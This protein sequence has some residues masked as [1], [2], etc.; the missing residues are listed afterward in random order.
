MSPSIGP[1]P[2]IPEWP[3][4]SHEW[5]LCDKIRHVCTQIIRGQAARKRWQ[6]RTHITLRILSIALTALGGAGLIVQKQDQTLLQNTGWAFWGGL[7]VLGVGILVQIADLFGIERIATHAKLISLICDR[8]E[9][10]LGI[11]LTDRDPRKRLN[12][13]TNRITVLI[14]EPNN[15]E[16]LPINSRKFT[17]LGRVVGDQMIL[18]SNHNWGLPK[19]GVT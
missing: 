2:A 6:V 8:Y 16:A 14:L 11:I 10:E 4:G 1:Q 7:T 12:E 17:E 3:Q 18:A 15:H 13:L 9:T 19:I 5:K